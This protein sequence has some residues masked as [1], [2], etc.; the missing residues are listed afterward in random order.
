MEYAEAV[1]DN[2]KVVEL[3]RLYEQGEMQFGCM[4]DFEKKA[5]WKARLPLQGR[6][7]PLPVTRQRNDC[8]YME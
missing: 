1:G 7:R 8:H 2:D 6:N 3:N 4:D 5:R